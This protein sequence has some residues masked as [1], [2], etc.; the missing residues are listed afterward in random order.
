M[1]NYQIFLAVTS[2]GIVIW[3]EL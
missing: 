1:D 2:P 3:A